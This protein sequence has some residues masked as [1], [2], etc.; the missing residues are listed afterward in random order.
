MGMNKEHKEFHILDMNSGWD[1]RVAIPKV[2]SRK[3]CPARSTRQTVAAHARAC[4]ARPACL[5]PLHLCTN[6]RKRFFSFQAIWS[7][8]MTPTAMAASPFRRTHTPVGRPA[9]YIAHSSQT[10]AA[11]CSRSTTSTRFDR[12][13]SPREARCPLLA[14]SGHSA[15]HRTCPL[16]GVKRTCFCAASVR[17]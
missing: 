4:C 11:C 15:L 17:F 7:S 14:Q 12:Q 2:F 5:L 1:T 16:L 8:V 3:S 10:A 6:T 13:I 9:L